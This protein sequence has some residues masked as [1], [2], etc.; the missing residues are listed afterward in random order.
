MLQSLL[1]FLCSDL[2]EYNIHADFKIILGT[3][4]TGPKKS[5]FS[6]TLSLY[7]CSFPK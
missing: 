5:K 6:L 7:L 1:S 2:V 3:G 4:G